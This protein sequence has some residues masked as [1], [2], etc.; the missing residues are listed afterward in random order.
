MRVLVTGISGFA[1]P[2]VARALAE[3]G[4]TV[5]GFARHAP[6]ERRIAGV[7]LTLHT[8]DVCDGTRLAQVL[9]EAAPDAVLHLAAVAEP[10][11]AEADPAAAYRVNLGGTLAVLEAARGA[12]PRPRVVLVS[13]GAVY[14]AVEPGDLPLAEDTP[15]RPLTVYGASK[16]AAEIAALQ[17][18]RAY[19]LDVVVARP[20]NHTGPGQTTAYVCAAL[21]SQVAAIEAA[22][23]APVI[24]VGNVDAVRDMTD[25]RDVAAGYVALLE[26]GHSGTVY[27]L[28]SGEGVSVAEIVAQLRTLARVPMRAKVDPGRRRPR[29]VD[30]IVGSRARALSDTGWEPRISLLDTLAT[31]LDDWRHRAA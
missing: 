17:W 23:Q 27:N 22:R 24:A 1:G 8:G 12:T 15:L 19:G 26:R 3:R 21:A 20:F 5:H 2:V 25:V 16:A 31:V 13:S 18:G 11:A 7:S 9:R 4:H 30:R 10:A 6:D 28:C 29:D 14:G